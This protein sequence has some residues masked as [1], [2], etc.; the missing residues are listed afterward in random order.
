MDGFA[1]FVKVQNLQTS[2]LLEG[3]GIEAT[4]ERKRRLG[5]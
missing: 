2:K 3:W 4:K 5:Y 1:I